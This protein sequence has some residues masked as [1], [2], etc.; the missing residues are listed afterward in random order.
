MLL[1]K[2][3]QER[4]YLDVHPPEVKI[5]FFFAMN[6]KKQEDLLGY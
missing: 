5:V 1:L 4:G 6:T 3:L 2:T